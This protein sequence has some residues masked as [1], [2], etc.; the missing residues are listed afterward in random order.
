MLFLAAEAP[1]AGGTAL[2][3]TMLPWLVFIFFFYWL[4]V[5]AP[6]K[7]KQKAFAELMKGLKA[8]DKVLTTSGIY[9][10]ITG[11]QDKTLKIRIANNVVVEMDKSAITGLAPEEKE[12]KKAEK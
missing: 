2:I 11:I 5:A 12:E 10:V 4:F 3:L 9:G 8:G 1:P 6:M 7:K